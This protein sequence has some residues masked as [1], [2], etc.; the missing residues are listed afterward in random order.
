MSPPSASEAW[1]D[2]L[3]APAFV[4][5]AR[6]F[7]AEHPGAPTRPL[8]R[9]VAGLRALAASVDTWAEKEESSLDE[10]FVEGAG[11]LLA[12]V[13]LDHVGEGGHIAQGHA[14]RLRLGPDGFFD[15]FAAIDRAL[16]S[17]D[18]REAL[19]REV[20]RAE[21][22][23][24]A[25]AGVGRATR[26]LR[27]VLADTRP[28]LAIRSSFGPTVELEGDV[29]LGDIELDLT[30][31]LRATDGE[32]DPPVHRAVEKLVAMLPGGEAPRATTFEDLRG[33][34]LPRPVERGFASSLATQSRLA[35]AELMDGAMELTL[36][37]AYEDRSRYLRA[38][39]LETW[40]L[41]FD[42]ALAVAITN[43]AERSVDAR[44]GRVD[45]AEG[46]LIVARTGDGLDAARVLLPTLHDVLAPEL[47]SPFLVAI[48]H[49]D[50]LFACADHAPLEE[51][52]RTRANADAGRA[53]HA[54]TPTLFRV[55]S[56]ALVP[57][58]SP[59]KN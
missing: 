30:S 32:D 22:E 57:L 4:E 24:E 48:P 28:A 11:A 18:A 40:K 49:R 26:V 9:G 7:L 29:G 33:R 13:L 55:N 53:P 56:D 14:H 8:A 23:A 6:R 3:E 15:P 12:L 2:A 46:P 27:T 39:E 25:R 20:A 10:S 47:G 51:A 19:V 5:A 1:L 16:E 50:A 35:H 38:D 36:I 44:F 17:D 43:L 37:V 59:L 54:I 34:L 41:G 42:E 31:L 21:A 45:T 58:S 52:M